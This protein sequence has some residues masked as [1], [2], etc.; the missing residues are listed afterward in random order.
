MDIDIYRALAQVA[1]EQMVDHG[2]GLKAYIEADDGIGISPSRFRK[3]KAGGK[4]VIQSVEEDFH[5]IGFL[6]AI[7][8]MARNCYINF[9][10]VEEESERDM[11]V[12]D[13]APEWERELIR[14]IIT[15]AAMLEQ[16]C[17]DVQCDGFEFV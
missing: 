15:D 11:Q 12:D 9:K 10:K 3:I 16:Y 6:D 13:D 4:L 1:R 5:L 17:S 14:G 2:S 8:W 7:A